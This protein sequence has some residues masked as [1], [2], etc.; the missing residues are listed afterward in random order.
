[1]GDRLKTCPPLFP[2]NDIIHIMNN[3]KSK[4]SLDDILKKLRKN[5][6]KKDIPHMAKYGIN[7]E[8]ALGV[9]IPVL[10]SLAKEIKKDHPL[11][12]ALWDTEFHEARILAS[13]I[14]D[15]ELTTAKLAYSWIEE[16]NSWDLCDQCIMNLFE[17]L[18]S[19]FEKAA[20]W[21]EMEDLWF[22]RA[23]FVMMAR[24]AVSDK[25]AA[26]KSFY[27]FFR[28]IEEKSTDERNFVKKAVNWAL[29]QIGKR[30]ITLNKRCIKLGLKIKEFDAKSARWIALDALR[31]LN[32][33]AVQNRLQVKL[34]VKK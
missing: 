32:S 1:M 24:L 34:K 33:K 12:L 7:P 19:A 2:V 15:K 16:F 3:H 25:K 26:D 8:K 6:N 30:N 31:E 27:P 23:G 13:M 28:L 9:K 20:E 14:A 11:A 10:R 22:R 21:A 18:P 4:I 5:A 29:R 17:D